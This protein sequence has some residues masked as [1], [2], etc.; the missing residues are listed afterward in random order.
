MG[1]TF[2]ESMSWVH[3][4]AG[5]VIG[6]L[7]FAIFW[8]GTLAV[9]DREIDRWMSP[10]TRLATDPTALSLD[11]DVLPMMAKLDP[12]RTSTNWHVVLPSDRI[13]YIQ[14]RHDGP[15]GKYVKYAVSRDGRVLDAGSLGGTGFI[16][17]FH[18]SLH[19]KV[20]NI[21]FWL[22][23][24]AA[25][26]MLVLLVSGVV[27]HPRIFVD[28]FTLRVARRTRLVLDL[29]NLTG[30]LGLPF[31]F[32]ITLSGLIIFFAIYF[33]SAINVSYSGGI[34]QFYAEAYGDYIRPAAHAAGTLG[35]LDLM[36]EQASRMWDDERAQ[37]IGIYR[38]GDQ[39]AYVRMWRASETT[40][41]KSFDSLTFDGA[42]GS[43]L[44]RH[45][46]PAVMRVQ[47]FISG[48]HFIQFRHWGLRWLYFT[49]GLSGCV[50]I[51]TG[52]LFW[53]DSRRKRH[54]A[55]HTGFRIVKA[56]AVG[57][58]SGMIIASL[59]FLLANR[60]LPAGVSRSGWHNASLEVVTFYL[61]WSLALIHAWLLP[62]R[63]WISQCQAIAALA[64]A[65]VLANWITTG[66]HILHSLSHRHLWN[67]AGMDV[68]ILIGGLVALY[69]ARRLRY[70]SR[71]AADGLLETNQFR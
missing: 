68:V 4:W 71:G 64:P 40:V 47:R 43:L 37:S 20:W 31:H 60:V 55:G 70:Q 56:L 62:A 58:I 39:N 23:G 36:A 9:F 3:T 13:P 12:R 2:R 22:V 57:S 24:L 51:A 19:L 65:T 59:A 45:D 41:T 34:Q 5:V 29:H 25:M 42:T 21:G 30:V 53:L 54:Q 32:S 33:P 63:A 61:A 46:A 15:N 6:A 48:F 66:D 67:V 44:S 11:R 28:F 14:L 69:V 8:M 16:N 52:F 50:M 7:L 10:Q 26:A 35:S 49:L 17:P 38:L 18:Y 1:A 27:V